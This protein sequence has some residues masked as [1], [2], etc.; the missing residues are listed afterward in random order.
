MSSAKRPASRYTT[1]PQ[2]RALPIGRAALLIVALFAPGGSGFAQGAPA[3]GAPSPAIRLLDSISPKEGG[4]T[5]V[6]VP[7]SDLVL[8]L[9]VDKAGKLEFFLSQFRSE[10][11]DALS[12]PASVDGRPDSSFKDGRLAFSGTEGTILALRLKTPALAQPGKY[13]GTLTVLLDGKYQQTERLA[14]TR[15]PAQRL[16]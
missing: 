5:S 3:Q 7:A 6:V 12:I 8:P 16:A 14:F 13:S 11:G 2:R 9:V 1:E 15:P 4:L 10:Q